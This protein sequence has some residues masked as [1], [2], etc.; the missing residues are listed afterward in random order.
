[1]RY[2]QFT[3]ALGEVARAWPNPSNPTG[4][5]RGHLPTVLALGHLACEPRGPRFHSKAA[6]GSIC[7]LEMCFYYY[8][9][10]NNTASTCISLCAIVT[11]SIPR[12]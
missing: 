7:L 4:T 11:H 8:I 3:C 10:E 1:M 6:F 2:S 12:R 5:W 9:R